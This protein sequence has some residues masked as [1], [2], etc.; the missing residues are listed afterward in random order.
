MLV[1]ERLAQFEKGPLTGAAWSNDIGSLEEGPTENFGES[2]FL[3]LFPSSIGELE[4]AEDGFYVEQINPDKIP[5]CHPVCRRKT[6]RS[7]S[8]SSLRSKAMSPDWR[9]SRVSAL[10][11]L[12]DSENRQAVVPAIPN[13]FDVLPDEIVERMLE[14]LEMPDLS[15]ARLVR[16]F[17]GCIV[18]LV[19]LMN[20]HRVRY[21]AVS[22]PSR[23]HHSYG[24]GST[25]ECVSHL[26]EMDN[27][28]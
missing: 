11:Q 5:S 10:A 18:L 21:L 4:L 28:S 14:F 1:L 8:I 24:S 2:T 20:K 26:C 23:S 15:S 7:L 13:D 6:K 16:A 3:S 17:H 22:T 27:G 19:C 12:S 25:N 9:M